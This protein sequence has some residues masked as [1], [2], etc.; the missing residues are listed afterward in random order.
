MKTDLLF[1]SCPF[2]TSTN[3]TLSRLGIA[4]CDAIQEL[5]SDTELYRFEYETPLPSHRQAELK[6]NAA[7]ALFDQH[8]AVSLGVY[9]NTDLSH[10]IGWIE[11]LNVDPDLGMLELRF[12]FG[13]RCVGTEFPAEAVSALCRYL[14]EMVRI[15]RAEVVCLA[16]DL[17]KQRILEKSGFVREG[18]LRERTR[19]A[20]RGIVSL[21][22][23]AMLAD[24]YALLKTARSAQEQA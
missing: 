9:A 7:D 21:A 17:D 19:W 8:R 1:E 6:V 11:I 14:F 10:L 13:R 22:Y 18:V 5:M 4:D 15:N 16:E 12:L 24:D 3:V 2:I 23:Y 20:E